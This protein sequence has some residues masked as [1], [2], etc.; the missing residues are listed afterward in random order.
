MNK[1]IKIDLRK[2]IE[3]IIKG[4]WIIIITIII[5]FMVAY[6]KT[7]RAR[8]NQYVAMTSIYSVANGSSEQAVQA[9]HI[10]STYS[11]IITSL[12]ISERA[13]SL[14]GNSNI[15]GYDIQKM[16]SV[17]YSP[18]AT[19]LQIYAYSGDGEVAAKVSNAVADSFIMEMASITG[20]NSIQLL[21]S[22]D[23]AVISF[24]GRSEQL[25]WRLVAIVAAII[26]SSLGLACRII[27]S[28][29]I[30][31]ISDAGLDGELE[32]IGIIPSYEK[33]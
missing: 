21:D 28:P 24:N 25:K 29:K 1:E 19:V 5:F 11:D 8:E 27:F 4:W 17:N 12:K 31:E 30:L 20:G 7:Y 32:I 10:M 13:A 22:A 18:T 3:A 6:I 9:A 15:K 16:T 33:R 26:I 23:S 14:L 2:C